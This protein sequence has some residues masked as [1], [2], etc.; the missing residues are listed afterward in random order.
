[1]RDCWH[2]SDLNF[3]PC[4]CR[5]LGK[6]IRP[7]LNS[8]YVFG[9]PSSGCSP[10]GLSRDFRRYGSIPWAGDGLRKDRSSCSPRHI[11]TSCHERGRPG[12]CPSSRT[13]NSASH[14]GCGSFML[15]R[16]LLYRIGFLPAGFAG[17]RRRA[18]RNIVP[19][20]RGGDAANAS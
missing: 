17:R 5:Y 1:M 10:H 16:R 4:A 2:S 13:A 3:Y 15:R 12:R 11:H 7:V 20:D 6:G 18:G 19:G 14:A 9:P 8:C